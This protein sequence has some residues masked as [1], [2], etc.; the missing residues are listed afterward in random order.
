MNAENLRK[1]PILKRDIFVP[2][3][4]LAS[5]AFKK[6]SAKGIQVLLRFL[7]KRTWVNGKRKRKPVFNNAGLSFTYS[8]AEKLGISISTFWEI[9]RRL[10]ALG[11]IDI[12]HQGGGLGR[13]YSRYAISERWREYGTG[14]F[15]AVE[16]SRVLQPGLDV[17]S[18][19]KKR[20]EK[21][22]E[23]HSCKLRENEVIG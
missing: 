22:T 16:K 4:M 2:W 6:L 3:Q 18:W 17:Q 5:P 19:K 1:V 9:M 7:Q 10:V 14:H 8:E 12:E 15:K 23:N 21:A 11:F 20:A 13:D